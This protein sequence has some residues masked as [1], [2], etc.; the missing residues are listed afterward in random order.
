MKMIP[1]KCSVAATVMALGI[2]SLAV[3]AAADGDHPGQPGHKPALASEKKSFGKAGDPKTISRTVTIEMNDTTHFNPA[4]LTIRQ[5]DTVRFMVKNS[6]KLLHQ[7]VIGTREELAEHEALMASFPGMV[8]HDDSHMAY[9]APG[10]TEEIVWQF[11]K[12]GQFNYGCLIPGHFD[13]GMVGK[14][15]VVAPKSSAR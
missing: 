9:V 13:T 11:T 14:I 8:E 15:I 1:M 10:K 4:Q 3:R 5:G 2:A 7:I 12:P 6:G